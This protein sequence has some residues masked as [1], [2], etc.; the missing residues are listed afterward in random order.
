MILSGPLT[1]TGPMPSV[2]H[3]C[4]RY[5]R[6]HLSII[7]A[8]SMSSGQLNC[9]CLHSMIQMAAGHGVG[10]EPSLGTQRC[11]VSPDG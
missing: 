3:N 9:D 1:G 10:F 6:S 11:S 2:Y 8:L 5:P 7:P 4:F